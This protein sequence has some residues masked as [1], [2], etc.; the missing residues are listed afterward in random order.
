MNDGEVDNVT[1]NDECYLP[2]LWTWKARIHMGSYSSM[3]SPICLNRFD[4]TLI[5]IVSSD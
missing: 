5:F 3:R 1:C 4:S 2:Q